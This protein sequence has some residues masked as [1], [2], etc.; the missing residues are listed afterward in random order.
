MSLKVVLTCLPYFNHIY[1]PPLQL[2][3][4]KA[5]LQQD[6]EVAVK[7]LDLEVFFY[8]SN[9]I[10][11][12]SLLYWEHIYNK[13]HLCDDES[14][15][16]LDQAV[17]KILSEKPDA[18]CFS[19]AHSNLSFTRYVAQQIKK[20]APDIYIIYGGRY[21]CVRKPWRFWIK[22][23][24]KDFLEADC[25]IK[26]EGEAALMEISAVLK[27]G[28]RPAFCKGATVR[29]DNE[30]IDGGD[31]C[32][33]EDI[34]AI[35]F[36]D[37][38]DFKKEDYLADYIR[39]IFSRGCIG[40][41][42]YCVENDTMGS[43]RN[44]SPENIIDEITLRIAQGYRKFQVTDL[45]VNP[46]LL[47]IS[48]ICRLIIKKKFDIEFIFSEFRHSPNLTRDIFKLLY[49]AGFRTICFGTESGSQTILNKMA[50]GVKL[51]TID[52]NFR[53]A[54]NAGLKV[55]SYLMVGFPGETE[56]TFLETMEMIRRNKNFINGITGINIT[57]ICAG[58]IIHDNIK[59]YDINMQT[60]FKSP[61]VWESGKG[62]NC[63]QWRIGLVER[64]HR[65]IEDLGIPMVDFIGSGNP[66]I[67]ARAKKFININEYKEKISAQVGI[68]TTKSL[69]EYAASLRMNRK[70]VYFSGSKSVLFFLDIVN[71]G[72]QEWR[73]N[74]YDWIRVGCKIYNEYCSNNSP[75][76]EAR[77][78]LPRNIKKDKK[79]QILFRINYDFLPK[80][81][82]KL[83][84]DMVNE[85]QF[86][87]EDLGSSPLIETI[88]IDI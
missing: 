83:K 9:L 77:K 27:K 28:I 53:D 32:L 84:F 33:I 35:P 26:N 85:L 30:I 87:F 29:K 52:R 67:P 68:K 49:K 76:K 54:H 37:F 10:C 66:E 24:H 86:W 62:D 3:Y 46:Q 42:V 60:L 47:N 63:I 61:D 38:S 70:P 4:L 41:C 57:E 82:Y 51:A 73:Q 45:A 78:E 12:D 36:P 43:F 14:K 58:S 44:R 74:D 18:A 16:I 80:G 88:N 48:E 71:I 40:Q 39:I 19:I 2:A 65:C 50:K 17:N 15:L 25:I 20:A 1:T 21:F 31:R 7:T 23:W 13:T 59:S 69:S 75:L 5:Y 81:K 6:K 79:F 64:M 72:R 55:I 8:H 34:N 11:R 56:D 22:E